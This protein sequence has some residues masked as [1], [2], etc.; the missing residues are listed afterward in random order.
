MITLAKSTISNTSPLCVVVSSP[1]RC[2][3]LLMINLLGELRLGT[4]IAN[5][6]IQINDI[7]QMCLLHD[8]NPLNIQN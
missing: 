1:S 6:V 4:D 8:F 5:I 7:N 2:C 3:F